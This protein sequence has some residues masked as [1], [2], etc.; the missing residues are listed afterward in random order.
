MFKV[1]DDQLT[2]LDLAIPDQPELSCIYL[3]AQEKMFVTIKDKPLCFPLVDDQPENDPDSVY[4]LS[5]TICIGGYCTDMD[6]KHIAEQLWWFGMMALGALLL[7][8]CCF[9]CCCCG[10]IYCCCKPA[11]TTQHSSSRAV[12]LPLRV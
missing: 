2:H 7:C 5:C 3:P 11:P 6:P 1:K 8:C 9:Y 12:E 10:C 4:V